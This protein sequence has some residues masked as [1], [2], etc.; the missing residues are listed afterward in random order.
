MIHTAALLAILL[1]TEV[2]MISFARLFFFS[3][4]GLFIIISATR[5]SLVVY[6]KAHVTYALAAGKK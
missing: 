6:S 3:P 5:E 4:R 2:N 1:L